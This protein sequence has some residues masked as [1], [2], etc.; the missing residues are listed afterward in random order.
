MTD[1][2]GAEILGRTNPRIKRLRRLIS[3]RKA[4]SEERAFVVEGPLVVAEALAAAGSAATGD[5]EPGVEVEA[6]F[7]ERGHGSEVVALAL[8]AGVTVNTVEDGVLAAALDTVSPQRVAAIVRRPAPDLADLGPRGLVMV[9]IDGRDPGN[10]GTLIRSAE[11]AGAAGLVLVG[12]TVDPTNPKVVRAS[13]GAGLRL[14][15]IV[16]ADINTTLEGLRA[17]GR[18]ILAAVIDAATTP[19]DEVDLADVVVVLGNESRGVP[20]PVIAQ[21]DDK[22]TIPLV[23]PTESLNLGVAGSVICFEALRQQRRSHPAQ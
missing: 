5:T 8:A 14:P 16:E 12:S 6:V 2:T 10:I 23:G 9:V 21:A 7:V 22:V 20:A 3:K 4:R 19:Y 1:A 13:A 17:S 18:R 15:V 11:A